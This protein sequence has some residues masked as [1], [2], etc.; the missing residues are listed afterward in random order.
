MLYVLGVL[1]IRF[2]FKWDKKNEVFLLFSKRPIIAQSLSMTKETFPA[3]R[4][5]QNKT[6]LRFK[7]NTSTF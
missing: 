3:I 1:N 5:F 6:P 4:L 7:P 2:L